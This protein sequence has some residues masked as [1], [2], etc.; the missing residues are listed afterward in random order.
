MSYT[1]SLLYYDILDFVAKKHDC[2]N[3]CALTKDQYY[4][5]LNKYRNRHLENPKVEEYTEKFF[6]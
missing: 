4:Y 2:G 6:Y 5:F 3:Q 1:I